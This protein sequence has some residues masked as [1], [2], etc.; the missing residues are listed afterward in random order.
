MLYYKRNIKHFFRIDILYSYINTR[1]NWKNSKLC[2]NTPPSGR[3]V[4]TQF[5]VF[6]ISTRVDITV[7][8]HG[9]CFIFL[10]CNVNF[11]AFD[12]KIKK[13]YCFGSRAVYQ[14]FRKRKR[15]LEAGPII[16]AS[17]KPTRRKIFLTGFLICKGI[18]EDTG[19]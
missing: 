16:T 6:P 11:F 18:Q 2:E 15:K 13:V 14:T 7:Y 3:R 9:K 17:E 4:S 19:F 10:K 8:Q 12:I 1:E 5:F